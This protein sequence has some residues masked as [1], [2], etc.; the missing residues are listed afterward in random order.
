MLA[1]GRQNHI[2]RQYLYEIPYWIFILMV[3]T[4]IRFGGSSQSYPDMQIF[5]D[6]PGFSTLLLYAAIS[7]ALL[8]ALFSTI[9]IYLFKELFANLSVGRT[10]LI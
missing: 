6:R 3:F 5:Y 1:S 4:L 8:G 9:R 2:L 10:I 7:G